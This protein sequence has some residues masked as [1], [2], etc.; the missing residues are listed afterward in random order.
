MNHLEQLVAEWY[1]YCGYFVRRNV[2]VGPRANGGYECELD[3]VAFSPE[4]N[5]LVH[6]EPSMDAHTWEKRRARFQ[7]KFDA[8]RRFIPPLFAGI[9]V[10]AQ[11]DQI[12]LLGFGS[13]ANVK[14]LGGGR[15]A[16][17][18]EF[19]EEISH[20]L[21]NR[22]LSKAAVS[23]QFPLLRTIQYCCEHRNRLF[24]N[25]AA[26]KGLQPTARF[27]SRG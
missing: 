15:V 8:G 14:E 27:A 3:V 21:C 25:A 12:A 1:E 19:L 26:N 4:Q 24:G 13:N 20:D 16:T 9:T 7:K 6:V 22:K 5:H 2:M 11:I 17:V 18:A 23:E 10:P